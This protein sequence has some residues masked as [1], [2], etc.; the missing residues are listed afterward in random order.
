VTA[1]LSRP[2]ERFSACSSQA[3]CQL[4][5]HPEPRGSPAGPFWGKTDF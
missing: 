3:N 2:R 1:C 5:R 4:L